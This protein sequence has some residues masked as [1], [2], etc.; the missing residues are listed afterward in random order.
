[1]EVREVIVREKFQHAIA[2][3]EVWQQTASEAQRFTTIF[4]GTD[5]STGRVTL[6]PN[7]PLLVE[8]YASH[9]CRIPTM[10]AVGTEWGCYGYKCSYRESFVAVSSVKFPN[11]KRGGISLYALGCME[12]ACPFYLTD[13]IPLGPVYSQDTGPWTRSRLDQR[14]MKVV[15][16]EP[17]YVYYN[18]RSKCG[19]QRSGFKFAVGEDQTN[20]YLTFVSHN[21]IFRRSLIENQ[22]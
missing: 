15:K 21:V 9:I 11:H 10:D 4:Y 16:K 2:R 14:G 3:V 1:M 18:S 12:T 7:V 5:I 17:V 22:G 6:G 13:Y 8:H 20:R 19:T